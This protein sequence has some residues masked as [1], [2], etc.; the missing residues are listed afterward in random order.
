MPAPKPELN[1]T[2]APTPVPVPGVYTLDWEAKGNNFFDDFEW[3][4]EDHNHGASH[5]M[6]SKE[7]AEE[8]GVIQTY[9]SHAILRTGRLSTYT[10]KRTTG[11]IGTKKAWKYFLATMRFSHVPWGCGVWPAFFS[12]GQGADWPEGGEMDILEYVNDNG[13]AMTSFHTSKECKLD[14]IE[15]NKYKPMKDENR[16]QNGGVNYNC[17]TKY[18]ATCKSLGCAPNA[19]PILNGQ[20][21][22]KRPGVIA[23][24]RTPAFAKI[25]FIPEWELPNTLTEDKP[26]PE[27][28]DQWLISYYPFADSPGCPD[29]EN[30]M[31]PQQLILNIGFCGDWASKVWGSGGNCRQVGPAYT[32]QKEAIDPKTQQGVCRAVDPLAEYAPEQDC[33][34]TFITDPKDTYG[35]DAYLKQRAY[36]N[37]SYFK[38]FT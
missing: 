27:N 20:Q 11:K 17:L 31:A 35:A 23:M 24:E 21:W 16:K 7:E 22:A 5:Y 29:A 2:P 33:C 37:I 26:D 1:T 13:P 14:E 36:Y 10:Y 38:V 9:D 32:E 34:T 6:G 28:W 30:I 15:V 8:N 19:R 25:F 18:C 3:I 12:L 4:W